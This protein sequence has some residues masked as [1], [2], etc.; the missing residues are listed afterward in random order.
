MLILSQKNPWMPLIILI[1]LGFTWGTG[2]SIARFATT[3]G[4][5]PLGYS[6]WQTVGPALLLSLFLKLK[7]QTLSFSIP[8][9]RYYF[10]CGL[11]GIVIPNT[12]MYFAAPHVPAGILAVIVNTV[13]IITYP[14]ALLSRAESFSWLRLSGVLCA[15]TGLMLILLPQ[16][17][18]PSPDAI[19][20]IGIVLITPLS[21][22]I[23]ATY[24][25]RYQPPQEK[26][27][28][29]LSRGMLVF[30]CLF[31]FPL[32]LINGDFYTLHWPLLLPD[33][34]ILLEILLSSIGYILFFK[35]IK[36][37]GPLY[38]SLVDTIVALTG[39]FWGRLLFH[40]K[41]NTWSGSAVL[42]ILFALF[43]VTQQQQFMLKFARFA[44]HS[45][46]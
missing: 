25:A 43:L 7:R 10:I 6:F 15:V 2:Y 12:T 46:K 28:L 41:L 32:T 45:Y 38:Y 31:L 33:W 1:I 21:F 20:W 18:L 30:A 19:P 44:E 34:I 36:I 17:N 13:P 8:L 39:L 24:I 35:L 23:C 40:E 27:A 14:I 26:G 3:N 11:T 37:A 4:V 9:Y 16:T 29:A 5:P 22:A 42:L